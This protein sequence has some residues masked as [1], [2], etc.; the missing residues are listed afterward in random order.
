MFLLTPVIK[1]NKK[2]KSSVIAQGL[3]ED[4]VLGDYLLEEH[5]IS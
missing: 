4:Y 3:L 5:F 2:F 1:A